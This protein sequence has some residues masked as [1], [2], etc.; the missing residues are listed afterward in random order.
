MWNNE[1]KVLN[2]INFYSKTICHHLGSKN[3]FLLARIHDQFEGKKRTLEL[4]WILFLLEVV[5]K[6]KHN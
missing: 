5:E 4:S 2:L 6:R 3:K 1:L